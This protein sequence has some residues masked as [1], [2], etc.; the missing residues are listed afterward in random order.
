MLWRHEKCSSTLSKHVQNA[1]GFLLPVGG[2]IC[3]ECRCELS[4]TIPLHNPWTNKNREI[5]SGNRSKLQN[6][7]V[8]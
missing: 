5:V 2:K 4:I 1:N 3:A 7:V 8:I 6:N